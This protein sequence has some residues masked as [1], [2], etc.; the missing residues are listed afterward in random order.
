VPK[1]WRY[2]GTKNG[3][4]GTKRGQSI[5]GMRNLPGLPWGHETPLIPVNLLR[6]RLFDTLGD[7]VNRLQL[8]AVLLTHNGCALSLL[9]LFGHRQGK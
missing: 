5:L 7:L 4:K 2:D 8:G 6:T 1:V 9:M 3:Q